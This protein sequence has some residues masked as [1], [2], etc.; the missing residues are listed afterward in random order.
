MR[1]DWKIE[2]SIYTAEFTVERTR[3][4]P[5]EESIFR[6]PTGGNV[7]WDS[8]AGGQ[9]CSTGRGDHT[10]PDLRGGLQRLL[11]RV[12]AGSQ[13]ASS[14]GRADGGNPEE[15]S[16]L[17]ARRGHSRIFRQFVARMGSKVR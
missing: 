7:R 11:V 15:A 16:E 1:P 4:S 5:H 3:H 8:G 13:P 6:R 14:A 17:G 12:P 10:Q 2:S 9:D